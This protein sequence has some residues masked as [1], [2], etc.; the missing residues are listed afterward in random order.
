[1]PGFLAKSRL[2]GTALVASAV[3]VAARTDQGLSARQVGNYRGSPVGIFLPMPDGVAVEQ[4]LVNITRAAGVPL[5]LERVIDEPLPNGV[6]W[7]PRSPRK[8][9]LTGMS[10]ADALKLV[11]DEA[12]ALRSTPPAPSLKY[13]WTDTGN[14]ILVS[15][16]VGRSSFLDKVIESFDIRERTLPAA[17]N[18]FHQQ[19]DSG[20]KDAVS[21]LG[22]PP[23]RLENLGERAPDYAVFKRPVSLSLKNTKAREVLSAIVR[24]VG[25]ASWVVRYASIDASYQGCAVIASSSLG[26]AYVTSARK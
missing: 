5:G 4:A 17:I 23:D 6:R 24:S 19:F 14:M 12:P 3:V 9:T 2:I 26:P 18:A 15:Q 20:F 25:D 8:V 7:V 10:L 16:I 1:V 21:G 11:T 22:K 13:T